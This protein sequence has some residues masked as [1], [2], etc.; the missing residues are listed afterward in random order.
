MT[1]DFIVG[2]QPV[3]ADADPS[4]PLLDILRNHL[5]LK[6]TRY[7]CG[8]AQCGVCMVLID[9][10]PVYYCARETAREV[11]NARIR[12]TRV[13]GR[14][15]RPVRLLPVWH[16]RQC[17]GVARLQ[18]LALPDRDRGGIGQASVP[19]CHP[20]PDRGHC[21]ARRSRGGAGMR[22]T[23]SL[24]IWRFAGPEDFTADIAGTATPKPPSA[25]T[26]VGRPVPRRDTDHVGRSR[27]P[28]GGWLAHP[29]GP[30]RGL[31]R[32]RRPRRNRRAACGCRSL[33]PRGM[34]WRTHAGPCPAGSRM[35]PRP[36]RRGR[37]SHRGGRRLRH[38]QCFR[39]LRLSNQAADSPPRPADFGANI[40]RARPGRAFEH[41]RAGMRD[42]RNRRT[43]PSRRLPSFAAFRPARQRLD[44][45]C[46][47]A[48]R[49]VGA[50]AG[51]NWPR[52]RPCPGPLHKLRAI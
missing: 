32:L 35:V 36:V 49:L 22:G 23:F 11:P 48:F 50:K 39:R 44:P 15:G 7:G 29:G 25:Y 12:P 37:R 26:I 4:A 33:E 6:G 19:L 2:G 21:P 16:G 1:I 20:H 8:L 30:H 5:D 47:G 52:S 18:P 51:G 14:T 24:S 31:L 13:P 45:G 3:T 27:H 10:E 40:L 42:G 28:Q 17:Q 34:D 41:L 9:G 43:R 46:G 38:A